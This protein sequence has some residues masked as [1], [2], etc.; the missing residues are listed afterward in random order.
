MLDCPAFSLTFLWYVRAVSVN[1]VTG[2]GYSVQHF[3]LISMVSTN[4]D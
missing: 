2:V 3:T 1:F 4:R